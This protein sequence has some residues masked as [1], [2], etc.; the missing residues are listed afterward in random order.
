M[1]L[2]LGL[3]CDPLL[4]RFGLSLVSLFF[5]FDMLLLFH[6]VFD[7]KLHFKTCLD[8]VRSFSQVGAV[9]TSVEQD[10]DCQ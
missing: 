7:C 8:S 3:T 9:I 1:P 10:S 5:F 2:G 6:V 4:E